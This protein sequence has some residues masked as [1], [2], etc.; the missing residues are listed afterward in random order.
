MARLPG[1]VEKVILVL[2]EIA[3]AMSVAHVGDVDLDAVPNALDVVK[4]PAVIRDQTVH[5]RDIRAEIDKAAGEVGAD[6]AEAARD[7][8]AGAIKLAFHA[9]SLPVIVAHRRGLDN[10]FAVGNW[11]RLC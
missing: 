11:P 6:E 8:D 1:E 9:E 7:Q 5:D 4:I 3:Q 10:V 2:D